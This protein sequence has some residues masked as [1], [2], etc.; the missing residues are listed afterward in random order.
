MKTFL[1]IIQSSGV[2][3][4]TKFK[5]PKKYKN[6]ETVKAIVT[7][8]RGEV[9]LVTN[10]KHKMYLLPGGGAESKD[11]ESEIIRECLEEINYKVKVLG[12]V[13]KTRE[14]R[15]RDEKKYT[16]TCFLAQAIKKVK[17]DLRTDDEKKY[18]LKMLWVPQGKLKKIFDSQKAKLD[19][20]KVKF[21]NISFNIVRDR[22]F[23]NEWLKTRK[24][25]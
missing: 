3:P 18:D 11:L 13:G 9:A 21:Y 7:N 23:I 14:F 17:K 15:D 12:V 6:R 2:F 10:N 5:K 24:I 20:G 16:T 22:I 4:K 1:K 25:P 8:Q 19:A